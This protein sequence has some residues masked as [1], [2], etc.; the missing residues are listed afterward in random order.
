MVDE[1]A[2]VEPN[3]DRLRDIVGDVST[4]TDAFPSPE[5]VGQKSATGVAMAW[6]EEQFDESLMSD[7]F[8][9]RLFDSRGITNLCLLLEAVV[10]QREIADG[11]PPRWSRMQV[12]E[13]VTPSTLRHYACAVFRAFGQ[14]GFAERLEARAEVAVP[15]RPTPDRR[16][17]PG[18][19]THDPVQATLDLGRT[20]QSSPTGSSTSTDGPRMS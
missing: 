13:Q 4:P 15:D 2:I 5:E 11:V 18:R 10:N 20:G 17:Q 9:Q 8:W 3:G 6:L 12:R 7:A 19:R 1:A 16:R 14:E